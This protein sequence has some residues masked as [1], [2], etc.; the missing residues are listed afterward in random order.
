MVSGWGMKNQVKVARH[1][2]E[3]HHIAEIDSG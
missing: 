1:E 3:A 2:T